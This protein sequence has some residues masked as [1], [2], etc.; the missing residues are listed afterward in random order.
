MPVRLK[1][2]ALLE[3][4]KMSAYRLA[5]DSGIREN[6]IGLYRRNAAKTVS[7]EH[8]GLMCA[9]LRC[10]IGDLME[11]IPDSRAKPNSPRRSKK[12]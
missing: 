2:D 5:Q 1:L 8:L 7:I 6:T 10:G 9:A 4:R 11:Y 3:S 12:R